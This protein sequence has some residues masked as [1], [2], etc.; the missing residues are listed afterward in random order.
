MI[1][2]FQWGYRI[3]WLALGFAVAISSHYWIAMPRWAFWTLL[4]AAAPVTY[5]ISI[6]LWRGI[7]SVL[8]VQI[9]QDAE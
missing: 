2:L 1:L 6:F 5:L 8:G 9:P 7:A 4:I 3:T